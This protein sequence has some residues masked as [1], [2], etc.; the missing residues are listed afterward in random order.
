MLPIRDRNPSGTFPGVV[1]L[2]IAV[3]AL[4]FLLERSLRPDALSALFL[5]YGL[6]PATATGALQGKTSLVGGAILPAFTCMFLH[7]GWAHLLGNMWYLWIFGDNV[8]AR[9]GHAGFLLFYLFC[10]LTAGATQYVLDPG[11]TIPI[12][13]ASGAIAGVLGAYA[14]CWPRARV[15]TILPVFYFI[16]FVD[17]PAMVVLGFWFLL[18]LLQGAAS[19]GVQFAHGGVAYGAHVGGFVVGALLIGVVP[20]RKLRAGGR[21]HR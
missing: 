17:V 9:L 4:V 11:S 2:L 3:N 16:T 13:G 12:V 6:V 18:Q 15:L 19:L 14:V 20:G 5:D 8:E 10:G 21:H 7:G 1:F